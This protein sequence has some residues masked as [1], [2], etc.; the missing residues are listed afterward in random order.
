MKY[1]RLFEKAVWHPFDSD[2]AKKNIFTP[3]DKYPIDLFLKIVPFQV[4]V[5]NVFECRFNGHYGH[6]GVRFVLVKDGRGPVAFFSYE[7]RDFEDMVQIAVFD[8]SY[9]KRKTHEIVLDC[10]ECNYQRSH[11]DREIER[12]FSWFRDLEPHEIWSGEEIVS[13][14]NFDYYKTHIVQPLML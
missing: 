3:Y 5:S 2:Y 7:G 14:E 11:I 1:R 12:D 13:S 10:G 9:E 4:Q 8:V 6:R